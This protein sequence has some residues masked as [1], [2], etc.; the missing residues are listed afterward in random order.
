M[1]LWFFSLSRSDLTSQTNGSHRE[2][3]SF[4]RC[5]Y[6]SKT[7]TYRSLLTQHIRIHTGEKPFKCKLC[8]KQFSQRPT[9]NRHFK[10][11]TNDRAFKCSICSKSFLHRCNLNK[12]METHYQQ[13]ENKETPPEVEVEIIKWVRSEMLRMIIWVFK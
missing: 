2:K 3:P 9:L 6:C 5:Q 1:L 7:F 10:I 8:N 12:H 4:L 11:H 13:I